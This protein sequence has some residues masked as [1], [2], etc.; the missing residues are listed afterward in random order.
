MSQIE[1]VKMY[2]PYF[3]EWI[4]EEVLKVYDDVVFVRVTSRNTGEEA[5]LKMK[6]ILCPLDE[7]EYHVHKLLMNYELHS[8]DDLAD[9]P[10]RDEEH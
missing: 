6:T 7:V 3:H 1:R 9:S 8:F 10:Y 2:E 4:Y 5:V